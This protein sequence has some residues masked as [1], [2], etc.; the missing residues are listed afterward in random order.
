MTPTGPPVGPEHDPTR[1]P[2]A[3]AAVEVVTLGESMV[4]FLPSRPGRLADVPS[5]ERAIGGAESNVACVLAAAGH[6]AKW[7]SRVGADGFGDHLVETIASAIADTSTVRI[8]P[9]LPNESSFRPE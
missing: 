2:A 9:P 7:V 3:V 5:F 8:K 1:P 4:T 6:T